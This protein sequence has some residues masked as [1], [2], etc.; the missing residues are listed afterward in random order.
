[1]L[2]RINMAKFVTKYTSY[3]RKKQRDGIF[4]CVF[5]ENYNKKQFNNN[6]NIENWINTTWQESYSTQ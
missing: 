3:C 4:V 1:M 5:H 6:N 2:G